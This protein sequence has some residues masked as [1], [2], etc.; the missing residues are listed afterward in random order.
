M[1]DPDPGHWEDAYRAAG[2]RANPFALPPD[3][4]D[5]DPEDPH[6]SEPGDPGP[7]DD[8]R[9]GEI[10][11]G[12]GPAPEPAA[13]ALI[14]LVGDRGAG[15]STQLRRWR[16]DRPGPHHYVVR[17]PYRLRWARP[18][19]GPLVY[20]DEIDRLPVPLRW[21]WLRALA[22]AGA[23]LVIGTHRDLGALGRWFGFEVI[24][25]RLG[26]VSRDELQRMVA[27]RLAA[28][29]LDPHHPPD[30]ILDPGDVAAIHA[31]CGGSIRRAELLSHELVADRVAGRA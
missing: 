11:R 28:A 25:H 10:D 31:C 19:T 5:V 27:A 12:L 14:Q 4:D 3:P 13:A 1:T 6:G 24:T 9:R 15:K 2:L 29:T 17:H 21:W 8:P 18:P 7:E 20:G 22:R 16:R 26:P 30:G 23:T